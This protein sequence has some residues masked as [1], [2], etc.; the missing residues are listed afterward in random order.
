MSFEL[1][2]ICCELIYNGL[3]RRKILL[4]F[5]NKNHVIELGSASYT[6]ISGLNRIGISF[7]DGDCPRLF[8]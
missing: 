6:L 7:L 3:V 5:K 2:I 1:E 8:Y 4:E